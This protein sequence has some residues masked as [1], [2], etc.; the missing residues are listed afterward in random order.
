[1]AASKNAF[2]NGHRSSTN[3]RTGKL[4]LANHAILRQTPSGWSMGLKKQED[5]KSC[6]S[7][8]SADLGLHH[9]PLEQTLH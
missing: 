2:L 1:M 3:K 8:T 7:R 5:C 6:S 4:S 9:H